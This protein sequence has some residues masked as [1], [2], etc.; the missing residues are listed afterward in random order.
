V[1]YLNQCSNISNGAHSLL[2]GKKWSGQQNKPMILL[3]VFLST[4]KFRTQVKTKSEVSWA[5][6]RKREDEERVI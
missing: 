1:N 2:A 6:G 5:R 4:A 3:V